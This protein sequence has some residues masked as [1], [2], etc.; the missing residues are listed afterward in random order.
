MA[1]FQ[2]KMSD[3]LADRANSLLEEFQS[4]GRYGTKGDAFEALMPAV[5]KAAAIAEAPEA[6]P[7]IA[8]AQRLADA[9]VGEMTQLARKLVTARSEEREAAQGEIDRMR[10]LAD[11]RAATL[12]DT[13]KEN[14]DLRK[15]NT[16]LEAEI[17]DLKGQLAEAKEQLKAALGMRQA[18]DEAEAQGKA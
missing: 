1:N 6:S 8:D 5:E 15:R 16:A 11:E 17:A 14:T 12:A 4:R 3:E 7:F 13:E 10:S 2:V 9:M 18:L